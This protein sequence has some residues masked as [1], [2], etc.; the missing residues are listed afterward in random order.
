MAPYGDSGTNPMYESDIYYLPRDGRG[1]PLEC[2]SS[3]HRRTFGEDV[4]LKNET[5][6]SD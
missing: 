2:T 5:A 1:Q 4:A 3:G 6:M